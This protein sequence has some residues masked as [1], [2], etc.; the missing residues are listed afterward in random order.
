MPFSWPHILNTQIILYYGMTH[1]DKKYRKTANHLIVM[2]S[3]KEQIFTNF[4]FNQKWQ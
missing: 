4:E 2:T 3:N 1:S